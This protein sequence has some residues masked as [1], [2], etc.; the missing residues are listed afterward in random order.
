M[1]RH[2]PQDDLRRQSPQ[3]KG[4]GPPVQRQM[5]AD[6]TTNAQPRPF[7]HALRQPRLKVQNISVPVTVFRP[8]AAIAGVDTRRAGVS[9]APAA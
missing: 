2:L 1:Q 7:M 4:E 3:A 9:V 5:R 8:K 6:A